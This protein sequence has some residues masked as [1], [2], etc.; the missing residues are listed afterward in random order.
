[1]MPAKA[2]A[3]RILLAIVSVG[4]VV[5]LF[6]GGLRLYFYSRG[7]GRDDVQNLLRG[8]GDEPEEIS[9]RGVYGVVRPSPHADVVYELRPNLRGTFR[10]QAISTNSHGMRSPEVALQKPS[11]TFRIV[12]LGD[13]YMF[14]WG[15]AQDET[16]LNI[17]EKRLNER[18]ADGRRYELLNF[19]TPGYNGAMEAALYEHYARSFEPDLVLVHFVGNDFAWPHFLQGPRGAEPRNWYLID[20]I[21]GAL[22][23]S[24]E[25]TT[26]LLPHDLGELPKE[27]ELEARGRYEYMTGEKGY[28]R[29]MERL[30]SLTSAESVPVVMM[31]LGDRRDQRRHAIEVAQTHGFSVLNASEHF[32]ARLQAEGIETTSRRVFRRAVSI[33]G[34][35]HPTPLA[36]RAY[37]DALISELERLGVV[38]AK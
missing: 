1:M 23:R 12:G 16:Y 11:D 21:L 20:L 8:S 32:I 17:I 3:A 31:M 6:E 35:G 37:A 24:R 4:V 19:G 13:S 26:E 15:V 18:A 36:H 29:A 28:A 7:V 27:E 34:D 33:P 25:P 14:G 22:G 38:A 5:L 9:A 2:L 30:A 10:D